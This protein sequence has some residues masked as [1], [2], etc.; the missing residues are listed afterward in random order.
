MTQTQKSSYQILSLRE[1]MVQHNSE[2]TDV[3]ET[4][5]GLF[6]LP[7]IRE[8]EAYLEEEIELQAHFLLFIE[9]KE[10]MAVAGWRWS[11]MGDHIAAYIGVRYERHNLDI[12]VRII[13]D[14]IQ[15][16]HEERLSSNHQRVGY[17][18][19][20]Y[21]TLDYMTGAAGLRC[22]CT[23]DPRV[24]TFFKDELGAFCRL[25]SIKREFDT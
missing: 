10:I 25:R 6:N 22:G 9:Q 23:R 19:L 7:D 8:T 13:Q 2:L 4:L 11:K 17:M 12:R 14:V 1:W 5:C 21:S 24:N 15:R 18:L 16:L 3:V 20:Q